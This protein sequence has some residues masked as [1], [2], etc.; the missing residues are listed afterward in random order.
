MTKPL[1]RLVP[2]PLRAPIRG[3]VLF[4]IPPLRRRLTRTWRRRNRPKRRVW[5]IHT[6][7]R[8]RLKRL[9]CTQLKQHIQRIHTTTPETKGLK[10][11]WRFRNRPQ[12][13]KT[14]TKVSVIAWNMTHNPVKSSLDRGC[15]E[16]E[17]RR[18][19]RRRQVPPIR[20]RDMG[21]RQGRRE[22]SDDRLRWAEIPRP[23]RRDG[24]SG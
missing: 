16:Q 15:V 8:N 20:D 5:R 6:R 14:K 24:R 12:G 1:K 2:A 9:W 3:A 7:A 18:R 10:R 4:L 23:F 11:E 22:G 21:T 17:V 19:D 13:L